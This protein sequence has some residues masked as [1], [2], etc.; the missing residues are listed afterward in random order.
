MILN[1]DAHR[2]M[3]TE[4]NNYIFQSLSN[5]NSPTARIEVNPFLLLKVRRNDL[6]HD[7]LSQLTKCTSSD[8]KRPLIIKF[9]GEE[10]QDDGG[11]R[12]EFFNLVT[13]A[14]V[15][16]TQGYFLSDEE[17][18]DIWFN[19]ANQDIE[20]YRL[21]G[22]LVGMAIY[23]GCLIDLPFPVAFYKKLLGWEITLKDLTEFRPSLGK[24]LGEVIL[25]FLS[26]L[27][28]RS[29]LLQ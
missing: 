26:E 1:L 12:K 22:V 7:C 13:Q 18:H 29:T 27:N 20:T 10:G 5:V 23:N 25:F 16:P 6:L 21:L 8:C 9:E 17:T 3:A 15:D 19:P 4:V 24:G 2:Q 14:I 11:I 28:H